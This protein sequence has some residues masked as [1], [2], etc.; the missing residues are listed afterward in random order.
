MIFLLTLIQSLYAQ[1]FTNYTVASTSGQLSN[2]YILEI[3]TD[4]KGNIWFGTGEGVTK[5]DGTNWITYNVDSGLIAKNV[6]AIKEDIHGNIWVGTAD[7]ENETGGVSRF[8]GH[9]WISYDTDSLVSYYVDVIQS[10]SAGNLYFGSSAVFYDMI[11]ELPEGGITKFDGNS[12]TTI[13]KKENFLFRG[14]D[15]SR[16]GSI[17]IGSSLVRDVFADTIPPPSISVIS[18][19][20]N[21]TNEFTPADGLQREIINSLLIDKSGSI[22]IATDKGVSVFDGINWTTYTD[23]DGLANNFVLDIAID[24]AGNKWFGTFDGVSEFDGTSWTNYTMQDGLA[25]NLVMSIAVDLK[26]NKWF[27]TGD[28]ISEMKADIVS[29]A[30]GKTETDSVFLYPNP[31]TDNLTILIPGISKEASLS[32]F[33]LNGIEIY[34][35]KIFTT[36]INI[37]TSQF[38]SGFYLIRVVTDNGVITRQFL[39]K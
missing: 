10:D 39:K 33:G 9:Q 6:Q 29:S 26:G 2:N 3:E 32:I 37:S 38:P 24:S 20:R 11:F 36:Y 27:G 35:S 8:N 23:E 22:W 34:S 21:D 16:E 31:V 18:I 19:N 30:T 12:W 1:K 25:G 4:R 28:G 15:I 5:F 7:L 13:L 17:W 14:L